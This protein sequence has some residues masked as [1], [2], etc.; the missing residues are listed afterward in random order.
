MIGPWNGFAVHF[1]DHVFALDSLLRGEAVVGHSERC[2]LADVEME[3]SATLGQGLNCN[4]NLPS[5][6]AWPGSV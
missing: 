2:A 4:P 5:L 1:G 6:P 3:A